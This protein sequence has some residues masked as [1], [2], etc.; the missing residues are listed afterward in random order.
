M[1]KKDKPQDLVWED[2]ETA[3]IDES[4]YY[5]VKDNG[6]EWRDFD[7][8]VIHGRLVSAHLAPTYIRGRP[9]WIARLEKD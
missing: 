9:I 2:A 3:K 6:G 1:K 7:W 8:H 4:S 5:L